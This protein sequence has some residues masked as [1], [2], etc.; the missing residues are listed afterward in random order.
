MCAT[1][2]SVCLCVCRRSEEESIKGKRD[3]QNKRQ[4]VV[5]LIAEATITRADGGRTNKSTERES[6]SDVDALAL[7]VDDDEESA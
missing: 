3:L 4:S 6:G 5:M 2:A 7:V 1:L